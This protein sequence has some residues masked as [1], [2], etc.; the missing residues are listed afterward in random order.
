LAALVCVSTHEPPQSCV[1][2]GHIETHALDAQTIPP[3]E[4]PQPPQFAPS[5]VVSTQV[6]PHV[7]R[8][9]AQVHVPATQAWA[10][11]QLAPHAPQFAA[12]DDVSMQLPAHACWPSGHVIAAP[13]TGTMSPMPVDSPVVAS[14]TCAPHASQLRSISCPAALPMSGRPTSSGVPRCAR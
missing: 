6:V 5:L 1:A 2:D 10:D 13:T 14:T 8:P 3:H 11:P 4:L 7:V 9:A 12:S